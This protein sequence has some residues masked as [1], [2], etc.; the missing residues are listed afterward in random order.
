MNK[1][2]IHLIKVLVINCIIIPHFCKLNINNNDDFISKGSNES[3][4]S[5][6]ELSV[7]LVKFNFDF[8]R[9]TDEPVGRNGAGK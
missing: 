8:S 9:H 2:I 7:K 1:Y 4:R 3:Q 5:E 6:Q